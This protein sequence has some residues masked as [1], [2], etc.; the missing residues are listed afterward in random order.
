MKKKSL[1]FQINTI[2]IG[3][4]VFI[5]LII[6]AHVYSY[7]KNYKQNEINEKNKII[8][9]TAINGLIT[10]FHSKSYEYKKMDFRRCNYIKFFKKTSS[11]SIFIGIE[12]YDISTDKEIE[13]IYTKSKFLKEHWKETGLKT[14][15]EI[16]N[17][18]SKYEY[19]REV[20][21]NKE[22]LMKS[23]TYEKNNLDSCMILT[24]KT[25]P[26]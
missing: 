1:D 3:I 5:S 22:K 21:I 25:F 20:K 19:F 13:L 17:T 4:A 11:D 12:Y 9:K 24:I 16:L 18:L 7:F 14:F 23:I 8:I 6:F 10:D 2:F 15:N 26:K